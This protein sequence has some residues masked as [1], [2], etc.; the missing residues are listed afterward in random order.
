V[1][2]EASM[3]EFVH[4]MEEH[5]AAATRCRRLVVIFMVMVINKY[6][7]LLRSEFYQ[8]RHLQSSCSEQQ[9]GE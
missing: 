7:I 3:N 4:E 8:R 1:D 9:R 6:M 5:I 2:D